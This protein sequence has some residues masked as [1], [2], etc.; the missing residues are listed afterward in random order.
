MQGQPAQGGLAGVSVTPE[1][2][3]YYRLGF[4]LPTAAVPLCLE[5]SWEFQLLLGS[6]HSGGARGGRSG[7]EARR[8]PYSPNPRTALRNSAALTK[9]P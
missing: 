2:H 6:P 5:P 7:R 3:F 8:P 4:G 1:T 9:P